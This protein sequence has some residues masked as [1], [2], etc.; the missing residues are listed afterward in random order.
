[1]KLEDLLSLKKKNKKQ[2][3]NNGNKQT[4]KFPQKDLATKI[5]TQQV[6]STCMYVI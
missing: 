6:V 1:M 3:Q 5:C 4:L 2:T